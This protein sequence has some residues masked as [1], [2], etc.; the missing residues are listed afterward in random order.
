MGG[1]VD[2]IRYLAPKIQSLLHQT[3]QDGNNML[4]I[5]AQEG[6]ADVVQLA[7]EEYRLDPASCDKVS[8]YP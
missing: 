3:D 6:H 5:A 4:H 8:V 2:V 1:Q 7:V